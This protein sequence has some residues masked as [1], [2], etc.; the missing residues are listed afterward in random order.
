MNVNNISFGS[1]IKVVSRIESRVSHGGKFAMQDT[2]PVNG[3]LVGTCGLACCIGGNVTNAV[4]SMAFHYANAIEP[5]T[6]WV[7]EGIKKLGTGLR[8]L[9]TGGYHETTPTSAGFEQ[10]FKNK[11]VDFSIIANRIGGFESTAADV[12]TAFLYSLKDDT[13]YVATSPNGDV[14]TP[15]ELVELF[16]VIHI[17]DN[18]KLFL[19]N[20]EVSPS[21]LKKALANRSKRKVPIF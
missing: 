2:P 10:L 19:G 17:S 18:D 8:G 16:D 21:E 12:E 14:K 7:D 11:S 4:D 20:K 3:S 1:N 9:L 6:K 5:F 13:Y 15:E